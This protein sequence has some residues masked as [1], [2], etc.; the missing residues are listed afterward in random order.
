MNGHK[1]K[2]ILSLLSHELKKEDFKPMGMSYT[3]KSHAECGLDSADVL[4]KFEACSTYKGGAYRNK[5]L[6]VFFLHVKL[7]RVHLS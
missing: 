6:L 2:N 3:F 1:T 4:V 7:L 5:E